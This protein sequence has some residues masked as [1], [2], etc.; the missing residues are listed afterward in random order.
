MTWLLTGAGCVVG[1]LAVAPLSIP[2]FTMG[3]VCGLVAEQRR[4]EEEFW[5]PVVQLEQDALID[6]A[7][8]AVGYW[9]VEQ[10]W[11]LENEHQHNLGQSIALLQTLE[12]RLAGQIQGQPEQMKSAAA[13]EQ[14]LSTPAH[15]A[16]VTA[17]EQAQSSAQLVGHEL[18]EDPWAGAEYVPVNNEPPL[19]NLQAL[20]KVSFLLI[21]GTQ[22]G[23]KTTLA[24]AIARM[25]HENGH[26]VTVADPHGA[27]AHWAPFKVIGSG[28]DYDRL[29]EFLS[30]YDD[31]MTADYERYAVG[32]QDF[33]YKTLLVDEFTQWADKCSNAAAFV[34]SIC[35][36]IRKVNRCVIM[37]SHSRT[38][39][40]LGDAKGLRDAIDRSAVQIELETVVNE[41]DGEYEA[42]GYGWLTYPGMERRRVRIPTFPHPSQDANKPSN[43]DSD[44]AIQN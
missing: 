16:E 38:L 33:P 29:N 28:R 40:G 5:L 36:D 9:A 26:A 24:K 39:T 23:R 8:Q 18:P 12:T 31:D 11:L 19:L 41:T 32:K 14:E 21:W 35:S 4:K 17:V 27:K 43:A 2:L 22:G 20:M 13:P 15:S 34:K 37:I 30:N 1:G 7:E 42:T 6:Q 25:R 44:S 10:D 3:M